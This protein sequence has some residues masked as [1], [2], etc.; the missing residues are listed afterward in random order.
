M[1]KLLFLILLFQSELVF[2]QNCLEKHYAILKSCSADVIQRKTNNIE[3]NSKILYVAYVCDTTGKIERV[4]DYK[5]FNKL[6]T[7]REAKKIIKEFTR[8]KLPICNN[9]TEISFDDYL[10]QNNY[11]IDYKLILKSE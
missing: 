1:K 5:V 11:K 6:L 7:K 3:P 8:H 4:V 10:R 9:E 2:S